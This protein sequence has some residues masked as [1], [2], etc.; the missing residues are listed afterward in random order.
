MA[1]STHGAEE[2]G[3][4]R[5]SLVGGDL[6]KRTLSALVLAPTALAV[7][8]FGGWAFAV[9][10][11]LLAALVMWEWRKITDWRTFVVAPLDFPVAAAIP[12]LVAFSINVAGGLAAAFFLGALAVA[13]GQSDKCTALGL[14]AGRW[15][16]IGALYAVVPAI[17]L[18]SLRGSNW[19]G[20][21]ATVYLFAIVWATDIAA[22]FAGRIIG[23]PK[24]WEAISPK[25]TISGAVG[26][27][28][29]AL[30]CAAAV[31]LASGVPHL[32]PVVLLAG[33][34]SIVS[35]GGDLFESWA[36]R[37][38]S[39]KD[40]S[41]LIPGHGGVMDRADGLYAAAVLLAGVGWSRGGL[42]G[43]AAG[44]LLW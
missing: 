1:M 34:A 11:A 33:V 29:G 32:A 2:P 19:L 8:W 23:G 42:D 16:G 25:K 13:N 37:R 9:F 3:K 21:W 30:V 28:V 12:V 18:E 44:V 22:Y 31:G 26:G 36:K 41:Q 15:A 27:F 10:C 14:S 39:V 7:T 6:G 43:A 24:L 40:S 35:Q 38:F 17:A 20:L 4:G 5:K